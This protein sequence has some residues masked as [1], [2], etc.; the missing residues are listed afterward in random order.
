MIAYLANIK[1]YNHLSK[2]LTPTM[3][4]TFQVDGNVGYLDGLVSWM[5]IFLQL[6]ELENWK[7]WILLYV[8]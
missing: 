7:R 1:S 6:T 3:T 8:N 2:F 4:P 5:F